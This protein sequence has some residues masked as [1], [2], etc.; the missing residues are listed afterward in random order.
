MIKKTLFFLLLITS[1]YGLACNCLDFNKAQKKAIEQNKFLLVH[2]R[3][4]FYINEKGDGIM[5]LPLLNEESNQ[6]FQNYI[7]VCVPKKQYPNLLKKYNITEEFQL[8]IIDSNGYEL[9]RFKDFENQVDI[10]NVLLNF[11]IP[12]N[13]FLSDFSNFKKSKNYNNATRLAIKYFDYSLLVEKAL[14]PEVY[15]VANYYLNEATKLL[16]KND[17][18]YLEK[19]E[20]INLIN[21]YHWAFNKNFDVLNEKINSFNPSDINENNLNFFYF[22]KYISA[23][24]ILKEDFNEIDKT[25]KIEGFDGFVKKAELIMNQN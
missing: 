13:F 11:T 15:K 14:K 21:L 9:H 20:K 12:K 1:S 8:L 4:S 6:I 24:G 25:R 18:S 16:S 23:K 5:S 22:L 17:D 19:I 3:D 2:F 10:Y 7:F